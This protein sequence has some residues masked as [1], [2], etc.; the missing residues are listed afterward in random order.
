MSRILFSLILFFSLTQA[1]DTL[2]SWNEG[3][4]KKNIIAYVTAVTDP[5]SPDFIPVVDR[6]AVFDNDGTLWSE[7]PAYF[8]LFFAMDRVKALAPQHPEWKT[9]Q[10]FKAVLENDMKALMAGGTKGLLEMV[11]A[12]HAGMTDE[13]FD[14]DVI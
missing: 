9:T 3:T 1:H 4:S 10:P 2:P 8:Q 12:T 14:A 11:V 6:I 13:E 5:K 7:Q